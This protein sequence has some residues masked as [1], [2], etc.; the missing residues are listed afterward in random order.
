MQR[1]LIRHI[2]G[3]RANQVD[4][5]QADGLREIIAGRDQ[6]ATVHFDAEREDLVSRQHVRIY[7]D[8]SAK[9]ELMV[10]DL[11]S[12]NGTFV[13][14]Q[15]VS[16][17]MRI[18]HG[19]VVQLGPGGPEFRVEMDPPPAAS[20]RAT[21]LASAPGALS[22]K[23]TRMGAAP[24]L[25]AP[26]PIGR[27][28]VER[29][30]D[31]T[32]GKVKRESGKTLWAGV[33]AVIMIAAV[34]VGTWA[35]MRHSAAESAKRLEAQ[36]ALLL[37]MAQVVNRQPSDDAAVRAQMEKLSGDM[38]R[39]MAQNA[40][41]SKTSGQGAS[42]QGVSA[43]QAD[44]GAASEYNAGLQQATQF[45]K[46]SQFQ[47]AYAECVRI[48]QIDPNRWESYYIAGLSAEALNNPQD[49]QQEYQYALSQ[50]PDAA[51]AK[52]TERL[53]A[54]AGAAPQAN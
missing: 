40:A 28:T 31:D 54:L 52:I 34:G 7:P 9:G 50:A 44:S 39:I 13:N 37:Q 46:S 12:R 2:S 25:S 30:L 10:A 33:A 36:Q 18:H 11:Q 27:A 43:Q 49:A 5:F 29:M 38:K 21:R 4:E 35:Y 17:P 24:D 32:F 47:D 48:S 42:G 22:A 8:P 14:R 3:L 23:P 41:L 19:D 51:K 15:R 20:A 1:I 6:A 45:Y 53:N 26:R 16:G